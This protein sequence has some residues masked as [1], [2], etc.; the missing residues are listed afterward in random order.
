MFG[1]ASSRV[2]FFILHCAREVWG[3]IQEAAADDKAQ[4]FWA[5]FAMTSWGNVYL[6]LWDDD[7]RL[8]KG[9]LWAFPV[10]VCEDPAFSQHKKLGSWEVSGSQTSCLLPPNGRTWYQAKDSLKKHHKKM[11]IKGLVF[12]SLVKKIAPGRQFRTLGWPKLR[13]SLPPGL[14]IASIINIKINVLAS[15]MLVWDQ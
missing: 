2:H 12:S 14:K 15:K 5:S 6:S 8:E 3:K 10:P 11:R 4:L 1:S 13:N 7:H 9:F